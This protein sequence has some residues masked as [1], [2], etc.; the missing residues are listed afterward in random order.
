MCVGSSLQ[1]SPTNEFHFLVK[2]ADAKIIFVNLDP[3]EF[4]DIADVVIY[5]EN[6]IRKGAPFKDYQV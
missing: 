3:T 1:V 4:D 5:V 2:R 6:R